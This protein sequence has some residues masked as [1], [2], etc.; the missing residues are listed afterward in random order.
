MV[1]FSFSSFPSYIKSE[2]VVSIIAFKQMQFPWL[3]LVHN[4]SHGYVQSEVVSMVTF[5]QKWFPLL[6]LDR[7]HFMVTFGPE[8]FPWLHLD[9]CSFHGSRF[10]PKSFPWLHSVWSHFCGYFQSESFS[11]ISF[12]LKL[13]PWLHSA[14][15]LLFY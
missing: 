11:N 9:R 8:S 4:C 14:R 1:T 12:S 15:R 5:G 2:V 7:I 3:H 6:H 13:F 10:S